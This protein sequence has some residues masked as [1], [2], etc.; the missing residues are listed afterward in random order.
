MKNLS[1]DSWSPVQDLNLGPPE[2]EAKGL[3]RQCS[4]DE[5]LSLPHCQWI[6][7]P[8]LYSELRVT[9]YPVFWNAHVT[10]IEISYS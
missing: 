7:Y 2:Y 3:Q 10:G 9:W 1:Q 8:P 6:Y 5:L 4:T